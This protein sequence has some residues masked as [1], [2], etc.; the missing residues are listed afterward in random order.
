MANNLVWNYGVNASKVTKMLGVK[1]NTTTGK[2]FYPLKNCI[3]NLYPG[4]ILLTL[5]CT[6]TKI[7]MFVYAV[8]IKW[9]NLGIPTLQLG[10]NRDR[11]VRIVVIIPEISS[12]CSQKLK[13]NHCMFKLQ[14]NEKSK[15]IKI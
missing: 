15:L 11:S 3:L 14:N 13:E 1:W 8:V 12:I 5:V 7:N 9:K 2:M 6:M 10:N 4:T